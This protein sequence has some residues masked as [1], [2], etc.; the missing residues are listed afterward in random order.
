MPR[1][2]LN[3]KFDQDK[4]CEK[5]DCLL[6]LLDDPNFIPGDLN[7]ICDIFNIEPSH[8]N[9]DIIN[10]GLLSRSVS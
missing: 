1:N 2:R 6:E 7:Q 10:A 8:K 3:T 9:L 4:C 5:V